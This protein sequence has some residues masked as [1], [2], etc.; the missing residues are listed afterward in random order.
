MSAAI[1]NSAFRFY[2]RALNG[3]GNRQLRITGFAVGNR[4]E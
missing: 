2:R 4:V 3:R 1:V